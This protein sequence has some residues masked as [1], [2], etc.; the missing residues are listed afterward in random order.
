M[1]RLL[2]A[3]DVNPPETQEEGGR[4]IT[5]PATPRRPDPPDGQFPG[6]RRRI[7]WRAVLAITASFFAGVLFFGGIVY[8]RLA[9]MADQRLEEGAFAGTVN[10]FAAPDRIGLGD[11]FTPRTLGARLELD[12]YTSRPD[13]SGAWYRVGTQD[14]EISPAPGGGD[15]V[16]VKFSQ[17]KISSI[18]GQ[19]DHKSRQTY[20]LE[21]RL[22][23]NLSGDREKRRLVKF[24]QVPQ[25]LVNT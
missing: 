9:R 22:L 12:G 24:G 5:P 4:G 13:A 17:G 7:P 21:P 3:I 6:T 23:T 10:I 15:A 16:L 20:N 8:K 25:M 11:S 19:Q 2:D 18:T 14:V 1:S